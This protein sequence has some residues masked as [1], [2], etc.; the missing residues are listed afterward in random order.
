M[1]DVSNG[2]LMPLC[3]SSL[4]TDTLWVELNAGAESI[5]RVLAHAAPRGR[6]RA[7]WLSSCHAHVDMATYGRTTLDS[8][9]E[10]EAGRQAGRVVYCT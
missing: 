8:M 3:R 4:A 2:T 5:L 6:A 1:G 7:L 9:R 10:A